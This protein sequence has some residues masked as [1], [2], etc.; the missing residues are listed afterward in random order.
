[1]T[2]YLD[3]LNL[4]PFEKRLVVGVGAL[5]FVVLNVL[6][7]FPHFSDWDRAKFRMN[8]AGRTLATYKEAIAQVPALQAKVDEIQ[9]KENLAVPAEEQAVQFSRAILDQQVASGVTITGTGRMTTRTNQFFLE[10]SEQINVLSKEEQLVDFLY[11]LGSGKSLIRVRD[12]TLKP[13]P[14]RYQLTAT[15]KLVASYQKKSAAKGPALPARNVAGKGASPS[16]AAQSAPAA[17]ALER[18]PA[19]KAPAPPQPATSTSKKT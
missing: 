14:P 18:P 16:P 17:P 8:K 2:G 19:R 7:V 5:L 15:I 6:F 9:S 13:D 11:N 3:K 12:L 10:L 1:M 4:R